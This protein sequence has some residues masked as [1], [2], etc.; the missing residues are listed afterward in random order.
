MTRIAIIMAGG[1]GER[2]WPLSRRDRPKQLLQLTGSG[3]CLLAEAVARVLP[4]IPAEQLF[5]VTGR[6]LVAPVRA[7]G[8]GIPD[9]NVLGEPCKR[10]TLGCLAFAAA[11]VTQ[12]FG[13]AENVTMAV[14]TADH[15]IGD[16]VR[17]RETLTTAMDAAAA[18]DALVTLG[19]RPTRPETG[20]GYIEVAESAPAGPVAGPPPVLPV[21]QF[22]EKPG[23]AE[24]EEFIRTGRFFWNSGMF[25]WKASTFL[26]E[27]AAAAPAVGQ[28]V[29]ALMEALARQDAAALDESFATLP[30]LSIDYA[31][32]EPARRRL[33]VVSDF[34]W[35]D[36]GAWDA[37]DRTMPRDAQG[38]VAVGGPVLVD[39]RNSIVYN[40]LGA[41]RMA[42][43]VI[44][45]E[46]IAVIVSGDAV[47]VVPKERA[48]EVR[49]AVAALRSQGGRQL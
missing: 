37:L 6:H 13:P 48:Q 27:L 40:E 36:I 10:N 5:V 22:R 47:L 49:K 8:I 16:P 29:Q 38:N 30:D 19:I 17:F 46:G 32:L 12:R 26:R 4:L 33:V 3:T 15:Q 1:S 21:V 39:T 44:G 31:L 25:V 14:L 20:Y 2:F 45:L 18:Q 23:R 11:Y 41:E 42:V 28:T 7:A 24:A 43:G 35:D 34:P 9:A